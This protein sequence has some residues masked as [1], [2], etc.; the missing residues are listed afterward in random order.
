[1]STEFNYIAWNT[2]LYL[3]FPPSLIKEW[4]SNEGNKYQIST[5]TVTSNRRLGVGRESMIESMDAISLTLYIFVLFLFV[6]PLLQVKGKS[7]SQ[8][9]HWAIFPEDNDKWTFIL[10]PQYIT[11]ELFFIFIYLFIYFYFLFF[12]FLFVLFNSYQ[13]FS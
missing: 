11:R 4:S 7:Q 2:Q 12:I 6:L 10:L 9:K 3:C 13:L 5:C 1:M 8:F